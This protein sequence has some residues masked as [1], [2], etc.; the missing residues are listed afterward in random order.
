MLF[1]ASGLADIIGAKK[2]KK[3]KKKTYLQVHDMFLKFGT[4]LMHIS[5]I[6]M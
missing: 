3:K 5:F 6:H 1:Q 4:V 2:M